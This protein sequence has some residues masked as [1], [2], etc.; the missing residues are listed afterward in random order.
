MFNDINYLEN[1]WLI[2]ILDFVGDNLN[3]LGTIKCDIPF[4]ETFRSKPVPIFYRQKKI[5]KIKII[6]KLCIILKSMLLLSE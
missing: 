1:V 2:Y 6:Y 5:N 3:C 4:S